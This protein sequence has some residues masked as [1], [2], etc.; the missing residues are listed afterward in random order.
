MVAKWLERASFDPWC[1]VAKW[2][3]RASSDPLPLT[4]A[5]RGRFKA[6]LR[7]FAKPLC[8]HV[9]PFEQI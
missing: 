3:E 5:I 4:V 9:S 2:L 6:D 8:H 7:R 1:M